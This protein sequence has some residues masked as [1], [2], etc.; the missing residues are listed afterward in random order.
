[1]DSY[2]MSFLP[3]ADTDT[4]DTR[5]K[6]G[7]T[8]TQDA[9]EDLGRRMQHAFVRTRKGIMAGWDAGSWVEF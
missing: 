8:G 3:E 5:Q 6:M 7:Q 9:L 4:Y 2:I 1:M